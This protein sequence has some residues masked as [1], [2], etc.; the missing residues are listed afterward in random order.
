MAVAE[1]KSRRGG[2]RAGAGRKIDPN[3]QPAINTSFYVPIKLLVTM[4]N[5]A[6]KK[7][8][9]VSAWICAVVRDALK[10]EWARKGRW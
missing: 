9:S 5:H 8:L 7:G 6:D 2:K 4:E 3:T 1:N 10:P